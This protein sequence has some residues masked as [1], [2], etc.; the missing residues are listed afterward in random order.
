MCVLV[1]PANPGGNI[2]AVEWVAPRVLVCA[3]YSEPFE[4]ETPISTPPKL[5]ISAES[6]WISSS[7]LLN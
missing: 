7:I 1:V 3:K 4:G 2:H 5:R 6:G